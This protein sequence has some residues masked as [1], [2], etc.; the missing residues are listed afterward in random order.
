M[1]TWECVCVFEMHL[2]YSVYWSIFAYHRVQNNIPLRMIACYSIVLNLDNIDDYWSESDEWDIKKNLFYPIF[3]KSIH[4]SIN[5]IIYSYMFWKGGDPTRTLQRQR[6][7]EEWGRP[8][9][10]VIYRADRWPTAPQT[11]S[12]ARPPAY[13]TIRLEPEKVWEG[14]PLDSARHRATWKG[15]GQNAWIRSAVSGALW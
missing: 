4:V 15:K 9:I 10:Q 8:S 2:W 14:P 5:P 13:D 3:P 7:M 12:S 1:H 11:S 6:V